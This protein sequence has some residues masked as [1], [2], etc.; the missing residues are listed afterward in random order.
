MHSQRKKPAFAMPSTMIII[1]A[2]KMIVDQLM[3]EDASSPAVPAYQKLTVKMLRTFS[4][5]NMA[6]RLRSPTPCTKTRV[7]R[8]HPRV[9]YWRSI[10]SVTTSTNITTKMATAKICANN[11]NFTLLVRL[12]DRAPSSL[13]L[14]II[15]FLSKTGNSHSSQI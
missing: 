6:G 15:A 11:I 13:S 9:V 14:H 2:M 5:S 8:P 4:V 7:S 1:P 3:P 12:E 10:F